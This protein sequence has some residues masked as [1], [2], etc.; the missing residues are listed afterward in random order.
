MLLAVVKNG[1]HIPADR[2]SIQKQT[3]YAFTDI[4]RIIDRDVVRTIP[5]FTHDAEFFPGTSVHRDRRSIPRNPD[6]CQEY[7]ARA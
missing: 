6:G 5:K 4:L 3:L 7:I 2:F 1:N